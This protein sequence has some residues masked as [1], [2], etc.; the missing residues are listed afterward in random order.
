[1]EECSALSSRCPA[2]THALLGHVS[3]SE[4][5][6]GCCVQTRGSFSDQHLGLRCCLDSSTS[7]T[8]PFERS[9]DCGNRLFADCSCAQRHSNAASRAASGSE[10]FLWSEIS[11]LWSKRCFD[12][13]TH[14]NRC[15]NMRYCLT[16][17]IDVQ[18]FTQ[19]IIFILNQN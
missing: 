12:T 13:R 2:D 5:S 8:L 9:L 15:R 16:D 4:Q 11:L 1:M 19:I 14:S 18:N 7:S 17:F 6:A 10:L 3:V